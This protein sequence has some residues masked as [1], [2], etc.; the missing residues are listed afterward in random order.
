MRSLAALF[1]RRPGAPQVVRSHAPALRTALWA[2]AALI[3]AFALYVIYELGRYDAGY[4]RQAAAQ[5]RTELEVKIEH[6]E[7]ER[8]ELRTQLAELDTVRVGR[9]REQ[10]ELARELGALQ[11]QVAQQSQELAFYRGVVQQNAASIGLKIGQARITALEPGTFNVHLSLVRSGRAE[12]DTQGTLVM[13]V[14]GTA[15]GAAKSLDLPA[16]TAGRVHELRYTFRYFQDFDQP[17]KVPPGFK[18][19]QLQVEV[20]SGKKDV[21]PLSQSFLWTVESGP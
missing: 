4:D 14:E 6:M 19:E 3:G 20:R 15:E 13:E 8:R 7:K 18:P 11:A 9:A 5:Q 16:L 21:P 17:L 10:A 2:A 1:G 12:A